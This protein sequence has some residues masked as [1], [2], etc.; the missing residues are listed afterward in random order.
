MPATR[1]APYFA[2]PS[3]QL[4]SSVST[5]GCSITEERTPVLSKRFFAY[6]FSSA[7]ALFGH[8][9]SITPRKSNSVF[10]FAQ[11]A[12]TVIPAEGGVQILD[13]SPELGSGAIELH[14]CGIGYPLYEGC[15]PAAT[16]C[17]SPCSQKTDHRND[18]MLMPLLNGSGRLVAQPEVCQ[19]FACSGL[20]PVRR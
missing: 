3:L 2:K 19:I 4:H 10:Y 8:F 16:Q 18:R 5:A 1:L 9:S 20:F 14:V 7:L 12:L 17:M 15:S 13:C 6:S 11:P